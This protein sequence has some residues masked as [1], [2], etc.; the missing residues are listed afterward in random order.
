MTGLPN[1]EFL[2][3]YIDNLIKNSSEGKLFAVMLMDL[4][5]IDIIDRKDMKNFLI[6]K[7]LD[8][9]TNNFK[10]ENILIARQNTDQF[11]LIVKDINN[12]KEINDIALKI[13]QEN[14]SP[15]SFNR[16]EFYYFLK[17]GVSLYPKDGSN[18]TSLLRKANVALSYAKKDSGTNCK[19]FKHNMLEHLTN[20]LEKKLKKALK[21]DEFT[22]YY[23]PQVDTNMNLISAEA[24]LRW[25]DP[26]KGMIGPGQF[27]PLAEETGLII[28]IGEWVFNTVCRQINYC[29]DIGC[30]PIPI[31]INISINQ[32]M[33]EDFVRIIIQVL[34]EN[35][36]EPRY[37][38]LE[39]TESEAMQQKEIVVQKME[40]LKKAGVRFILDDFGKGYSSLNYL[41][42]LPIDII[43]IDKSF[44]DFITTSKRDRLIVRTVIEIAHSLNLKVIAEG[45]ETEQQLSILTSEKCDGIQGYVY[46]PPLPNRDF[47]KKYLLNGNL[48]HG[49]QC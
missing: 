44:I 45:V 28:P 19:F 2:T 31:S 23:Q 7:I 30:T 24:L 11:A 35:E 8:R 41:R 17:I 40:E 22:L 38:M 14:S 48:R 26:E 9:I 32:L 33:Q 3:N 10:R 46:S 4:E 49:S 18:T 34:K 13:T 12:L 42:F 47:I 25:E 1:V 37:L 39:I 43:K 20:N 21:S 15:I 5:A 27:I 36:I 6:K 16:Q 29:K